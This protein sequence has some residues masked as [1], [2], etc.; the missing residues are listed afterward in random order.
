MFVN[1]IDLYHMCTDAAGDE[2]RIRAELNRWASPDTLD[3]NS[4]QPALVAACERG[5]P[6]RPPRAGDAAGAAAPLQA[7][8]DA[9]IRATEGADDAPPPPPS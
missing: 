4:G 6:L 3:P 7:I 8:V 5:T 1:S 9:V 2:R